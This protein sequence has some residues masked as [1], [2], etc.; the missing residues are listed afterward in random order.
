MVFFIT[1]KEKDGVVSLL[2]EY[3]DVF[4]WSY[5]DKP[6]LDTGI[7]VHKIPLIEGSKPVKQ[8]SRRMH[9]NILLKVKAKIQK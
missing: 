6:N 5:V 2:Q 3:A 8:K 1:V 9:S 7:V 4:A